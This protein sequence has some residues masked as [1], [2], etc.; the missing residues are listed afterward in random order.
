MKYSLDCLYGNV[1]EINKIAGLTLTETTYVSR[2]KLARHSHEFAYFCFVLDGNFTENYERRTRSCKPAS[3]IFHPPD[4]SHSDDFHT[5]ARC[6]NVQMDNFWLDRVRQFSKITDCSAEFQGGVTSRLAMKIY[7]KFRVFDNLSALAI[8]G[9]ALELIAEASRHSAK[10]NKIPRWLKTAQEMLRERF[11]E[12]LNITHIAETVGVHP[13]HLAREFRRFHRCTI[14]DYLR[15][16]RIEFACRTISNSN[17]PLSEVALS[18]GFFDQS[19]FARIFKQQT[20]LTPG[21]YRKN[22]RSR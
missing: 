22:F 2:L 6:F 3:L 15:Q 13:A 4:E 19:H 17:A 21:Q 8:E 9:L 7:R 12:R 16:L 1:T 18:A 11:S 10:E 14:G 5:E 20:G